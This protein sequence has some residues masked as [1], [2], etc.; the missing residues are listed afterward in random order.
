MLINGLRVTS[1]FPYK[2]RS[3][4]ALRVTSYFYRTSCVLLFAYESL[5]TVYYTSYELLLLQD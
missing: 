4:H 1:Y 2:L 3:L 5:V